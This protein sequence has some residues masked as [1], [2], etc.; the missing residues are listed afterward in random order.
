M[1]FLLKMVIFHCYVGLQFTTIGESGEK[2]NH[3]V[4]MNIEPNASM[5][6]SSTRWWQLEYFLFS[7]RISG[8]M[9]QF[10]EHIFQF[11]WLIQ[12]PV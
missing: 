8:E 2:R 6:H 10:D 4:M 12:S 7:P 1:Y 3:I 11:G 5:H 9:I